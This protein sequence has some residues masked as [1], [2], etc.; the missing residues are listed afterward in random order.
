MRGAARTLPAR[1]SRPSR[2]E[3]EVEVVEM[4]RDQCPEGPEGIGLDTF[5]FHPPTQWEGREVTS[6]EGSRVISTSILQGLA[7]LKQVDGSVFNRVYPPR[8]FL[9]TLPKGG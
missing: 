2:R 9:A 3:G 6:G 4:C 1:S 7:V 5:S 8:S